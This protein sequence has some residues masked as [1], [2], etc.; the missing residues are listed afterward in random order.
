MFKLLRNGLFRYILHTCPKT[1]YGKCPRDTFQTVSTAK[2]EDTP[3]LWSWSIVVNG[4]G[5]LKMPH[6]LTCAR[7]QQKGSE[8]RLDKKCDENIADTAAKR[9]KPQKTNPVFRAQKIWT[10][11][12]SM[13]ITVFYWRFFSAHCNCADL[14]EFLKLQCYKTMGIS[15]F[16]C[17]S[18]QRRSL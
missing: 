1:M 17:C 5:G 16:F 13:Q 14:R 6:A 12:N 3:M 15:T 18:Q 8:A 4:N 10:C 11:Y 2:A 7:S 9:K